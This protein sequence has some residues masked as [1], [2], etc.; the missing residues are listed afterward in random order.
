MLGSIQKEVKEF[1]EF[2]PRYLFHLNN[3]VAWCYFT[4]KYSHKYQ[5]I[6][7][8]SMAWR[9]IFLVQPTERLNSKNGISPW[10]ICC[11]QPLVF[12]PK[13]CWQLFF[14]QRKQAWWYIKAV[15]MET[16]TQMIL[17]LWRSKATPWIVWRAQWRFQNFI[18]LHRKHYSQEFEMLSSPGALELCV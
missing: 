10:K 18:V 3:V 11:F 8:Y 15:S 12:T 16:W 14:G 6:G 2:K 17:G 4:S 13:A 5:I 9:P 1:W 7:L